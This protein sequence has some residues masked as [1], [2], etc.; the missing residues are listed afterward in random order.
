MNTHDET[1]KIAKEI[2]DDILNKTFEETK[3]ASFKEKYPKFFSM[4]QKPNMDESMF[5]KMVELL[6]ISNRN[7][8]ESSSEFSQFG[9]E[10]Y[11]YPKFGKPSNY[12]LDIA[13]EKISKLY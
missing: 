12:E 9:A 6:S 2:R 8:Q 3:Y 7:E 13:K 4:L 5:N 1:L 11:L 10:K